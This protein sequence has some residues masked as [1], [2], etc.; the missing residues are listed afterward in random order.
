MR[1]RWVLTGIVLGVI[2]GFA[3][4][5]MVAYSEDEAKETYNYIGV[6]KCKMC[7]NKEKT[8]AQFSVWEKSR[9]AGAYTALAS[10]EAKKAAAELGIEDPQKSDKCL[11]C[12]A[13]AFPVMADLENQKITL[14]EG[15]SCESCHGPGSGYKKMKVMKDIHAGTV[16]GS[17]VGLVKPD[18][19][20]CTG[21]HKAEGNPFH[22]EF[23]FDEF[24]AKIA[25]K[26][27][28]AVPE[29]K[30]K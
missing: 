3:L 9:H 16:D 27:P 1:N 6:K 11:V 28:E 17:T 5:S 19:E 24:Y 10:D 22:K 15:V 13:T 2:A 25:H 20:V 26:I 4:T 30:T 18:A 14:E 29:A 21:C 8:G 23:K 12:H 7:H